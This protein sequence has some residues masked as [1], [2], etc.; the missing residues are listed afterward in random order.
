MDEQTATKMLDGLRDGQVEE[1]VINKED[2][3]T[4]RPFL[5]NRDDF[6]YFHGT[7][8]RGGHFTYRYLEK[9]RS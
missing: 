6:K 3:L 2:F 7:A 5:V 8:G 9:P 4:F 1:I